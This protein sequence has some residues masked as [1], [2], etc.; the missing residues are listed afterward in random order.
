MGIFG[1]ISSAYLYLQIVEIDRALHHNKNTILRTRKRKSKPKKESPTGRIPQS[2]KE[3]S[4]TLFTHRLLCAGMEGEKLFGAVWRGKVTVIS[5]GTV[6]SQ[7]QGKGGD[8][9]LLAQC[10]GRCTV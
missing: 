3:V 6:P 4:L 9:S 10:T 8:L 2:M 1:F 7:H 5:D